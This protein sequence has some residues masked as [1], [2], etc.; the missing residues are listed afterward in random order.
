MNIIIFGGAFDPIHHGHLNMAQKA[1]KDLDGEVYF[2]P[3]P[4]S[5][6]KDS[7]APIED[8]IN[9]IKLAIEGNEHFHIDTFEVDSGKKTNYSIDTVRYFKNRYPKDN[10]FYLIGGDQVNEFHRWKDAEELASLARIV[11]FARPDIILKNDNKEKFHMLEIKGSGIIISSSD[12]RELKS[13]DLPDCVIDYIAEHR[14]YYVKKMQSYIKERRLSHSIS[15]AKTAYEIAKANKLENPKR[16]Y[17]AGL[18]HDIGKWNNEEK[19]RKVVEE[20]FKEYSSMPP[21]SFHQFAGA[22]TAK[23]DFGIVDEEML[24]A[25]KFHATGSDDMGP[26]AKIVYAA[27]KIEPTRG[28]DSS[29]L[30]SAMK[31]NYETGFKIVL[32]ANK[33]FLESHRGNIDNP[34]TSNCFKKYL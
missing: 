9:M 22:Y 10:I 3:A 20:H 15:V 19:E 11:Y 16:A 33:E 25:I 7:S 14:L 13:L 30:I 29:D 17:I 21:F 23:N 4:I 12:I 1:Q 27:D 34:L 26:L 31:E 2:V 28:F 32:Q 18:L 5:V 6:W 8:K 24:N